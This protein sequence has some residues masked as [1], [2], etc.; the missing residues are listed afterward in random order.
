[1]N[2]VHISAEC[3]PAAKVGGL[4][5]VVGSLPK[6][7]NRIGQSAEV[8]MP[9][10]RTNWIKSRETRTIYRGRAPYG[11]RSFEFTVLQI[12]KELLGFPLYL[13][14]IPGKLDRE[15]IYI[16][17]WSG[18]PYWDEMD[19]FFS[20]QVAYLEWLREKEKKPDVIHCHDHH[21]AL[22]PF[23]ITRCF[24]YDDLKS[25][26]TIVTIHNGE[27]QGRYNLQNYTRL[28]AFPIEHLGLLDWNGELNALAAGIKCAWKV[29]TVSKSYMEELLESCHG[30][31]QLLQMEKE[32]TTGLI[33]GIDTEIWDPA[34]DPH[35][36]KNY[37]L[38]SRKS[39]KRANKKLLSEEFGLDNSRPLFS[40]IGR[41]VRE[42]GADL[43][44]RLIEQAMEKKLKLSILV[45]GTGDPGFHTDLKRLRGEHVGFFDARLEYNETLAHNIYAGSDF[46]LMPSR[47]EPCG[48]NQ[49]YAMRYGT[50]PVVRKTGGL[51]DTVADIRKKNGYG[52]LFEAYS[53][54]DALESVERA[55]QFYHREKQF[56]ENRKRIMKLDFSWEKA[57]EKYVKMYRALK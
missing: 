4:A 5:D 47:V 26:P 32:K 17:P 44:V 48:L 15:G 25:I 19:R 21:T 18:Q 43:L 13:I 28:P 51:A 37:T 23:M 20:F 7:L 50:V 55:V 6:Y 1:M 52:I 24:R 57:S 2:I 34:E 3:Y 11:N 14:D 56:D 22:V 30:L 46:L 16:D 54:K 9:A 41:L 27:Y 40:F 29:T 33:N 38:R 8:V 39:G 53:V 12:D 35:L 36:A 45:L 49:M 42:K 31:E 10:Y